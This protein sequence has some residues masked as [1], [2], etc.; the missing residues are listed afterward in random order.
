[1]SAVSIPL[2]GK[3]FREEQN[4][5]LFKDQSAESGRQMTREMI[6]LRIKFLL[7]VLVETSL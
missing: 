2:L 4:F 3:I 7:K 5:L 6:V 1:M